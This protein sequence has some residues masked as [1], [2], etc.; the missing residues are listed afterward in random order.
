MRQSSGDR[1]Q[2]KGAR[3]WG[4]NAPL[5]LGRLFSSF[6]E[7]ELPLKIGCCHPSC[8]RIPLHKTS[9]SINPLFTSSITLTAS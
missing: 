7:F 6:E 8:S 2:L 5:S 1:H 3:A 9:Q 4:E